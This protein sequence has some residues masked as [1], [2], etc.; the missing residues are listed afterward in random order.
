M[1]VSYNIPLVF[2]S[3]TCDAFFWSNL[4]SDIVIGSRST[5]AVAMGLKTATGIEPEEYYNN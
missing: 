5:I 2:E 4:K 3:S 1:L